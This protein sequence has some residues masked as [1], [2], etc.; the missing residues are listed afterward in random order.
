VK[1]EFIHA[2][3]GYKTYAWGHD[4]L[5]PLSKSAADWYAEP[6]LMTPVDAFSTMKIMHLNKRAQEAKQLILETLSFDKDFEV[7]LFEVNIRLLGGLLSAYQLDGDERFLRLAIDLGDRLLPA[8]DSPTGMPYRF[9]NL[10]SGAVRDASNNPAEIA[11]LLLE[12]GT[13]S[14]HAGNPAYYEKAGRAVRALFER[15][16]EIDLVGT[17]INVESGEWENTESHASARIDSYYEYLLKGWLMFGDEELGRMWKTSIEAANKYLPDQL[18]SGL[19]YGRADMHTGVRTHTYFG[20]L[21]AFLPAVLALGGDLKRAAALQ[22]SCYKLW[23]LT[24]IEPELID[25]ATM[26]VLYD[27]YVLRPENIESAYYLYHFTG[28][29]RYEEMGK[30]YF[31][32]LVKYCRCDAG[33]AALGS[34]KSKE[35]VDSMQSFF[36]AE[37]LKYCYLLF[38]D[39]STVDFEKTLF[40]TEAHP[41]KIWR[42]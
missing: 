26:E 1:S 34:V 7:Q 41:L 37:T 3:D 6:L 22:E 18:Q 19:W 21:D 40:N 10:R 30:T 31:E 24:G 5:K 33:Y 28:D 14:K 15:R 23:T 35:Q 25:Y 38:A 9:V 17:I 20:A 39:D 27:G 29:P 42:E 32:S 13:L 2:W 36:L 16:S 12:W 8:F 11:T 4:D